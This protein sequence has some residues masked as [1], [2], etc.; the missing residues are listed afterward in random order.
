MASRSFFGTFGY[1][2]TSMSMIAE[3]VAIKKPSLYSHYSSKEEIFKDVLDK[4]MN[5]YVTYLE[6]TLDDN[7]RSVMDILRDLMKN[8]SLDSEGDAS[9][10]FYYRYARYQP[11]ELKAY[12]MDKYTDSEN[13]ARSL[14]DDIIERGK[15]EGEIDGALSNAQIYSTYFLL[16]DGLAVTPDFYG[17]DIQAAEFERVWEVFQRGVRPS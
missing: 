11:Q 7:E 5:D 14:F 15:R 8:M 12:I 9:A 3:A 16:A 6:R 13:V 1:E 2:A 10:D 4:E 17:K